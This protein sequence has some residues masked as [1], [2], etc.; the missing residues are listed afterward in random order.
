MENLNQ[1]PIFDFEIM[2][3]NRYHYENFEI[4]VYMAPPTKGTWRSND[5]VSAVRLVECKMVF[6]Q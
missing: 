2:L 5:N 6:I 4:I 3:L 1:N